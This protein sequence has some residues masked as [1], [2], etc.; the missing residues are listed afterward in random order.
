MTE[1]IGP[2]DLTGYVTSGAN[3][4]FARYV[5]EQHAN[6]PE[7]VTRGDAVRDSLARCRAAALATYTARKAGGEFVQ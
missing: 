1:D 4:S 7:R 3:G 5:H 2:E 6:P